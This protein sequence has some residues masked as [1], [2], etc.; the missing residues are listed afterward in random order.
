MTV[1][2]MFKTESSCIR[3]Q[4]FMHYYICIK[5]SMFRMTYINLWSKS[6][7]LVIKRH[8]VI[9]CEQLFLFLSVR[10]HSVLFLWVKEYWAEIQKEG[11]VA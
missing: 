9:P 2:L 1:L 8:Q 4:P 6:E 3:N 5:L 11:K 10:S 7:G